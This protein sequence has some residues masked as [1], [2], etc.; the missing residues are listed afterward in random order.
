MDITAVIQYI[1]TVAQS[2]GSEDY[3]NR[4]VMMILGLAGLLFCENEQT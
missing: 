4:S 1:L 2:F 3:Y